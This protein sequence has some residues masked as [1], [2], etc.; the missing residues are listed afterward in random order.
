MGNSELLSRFYLY[1]NFYI[2]DS[3]SHKN[4]KG[5]WLAHSPEWFHLFVFKNPR[6]DLLLLDFAAQDLPKEEF[7]RKQEIE[8]GSIVDY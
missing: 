7:Q 4:L 1:R 3:A 5:E 8:C 2:D 6:K